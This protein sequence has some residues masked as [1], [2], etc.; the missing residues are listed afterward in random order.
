[1]NNILDRKVILLQFGNAETQ[2]LVD[3]RHKDPTRLLQVLAD[4]I[5]IGHNLKFDYQVIK[6]NYGVELVRVFDT[7]LATQILECGKSPLSKKGWFGLEGVCNRY[8][9][10]HLYGAQGTLFRPPITKEIRKSF[11]NVGNDPF[12]ISQLL[13]AALDVEAV[14]RLYKPLR[15][16]LASSELEATNS[17]E[18]EF[19]FVL[20]DMELAGI[21]LNQTQWLANYRETLRTTETLRNELFAVHAINWDSWQQVLPVMKS[22]NVD[23]SII[24][25]E[26]GDIKES[27]SRQVLQKQVGVNPILS[28]YLTYKQ[29]KKETSTYGEGFLKYVNPISGRVHSSFMQ[30]M[31]TGRT[32]STNPNIQNIKRGA[33]YRSAFQADEG[34]VFVAADFSNIEARI[35]ADKC[36]DPAFRAAFENDGDYHLATARIAFDNPLLTKDSEERSLAKNINFSIAYGG[37]AG[38]LYEKY[39]VPLRRGR[40][41]IDRVYKGFPKLRE[42]FDKQGAFAK[43]HGYV[44][45]NEI[46]KRRSYI[47]F[48]EEYKNYKAH[49]EYFRARG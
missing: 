11:L 36:G 7:M 1:L 31:R 29:F 43:E 13:Y 49:I 46:T 18:G 38:T 9:D 35:L 2:Y 5:I 39:R 26:T 25:K 23:V 16:K 32:S 3:T 10:V 42:Y 27:V 47:P 24:D 34:D 33:V 6:D 15:L 48:F 4:K 20:A 28:T 12:S 45:A 14:F 17:L 19:M 41:L 30:I 21:W 8:L 44:I 37:G 40:E 22:Y